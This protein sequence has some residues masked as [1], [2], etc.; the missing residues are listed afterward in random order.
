MSAPLLCLLLL[1]STFIPSS[2]AI[3]RAA[4]QNAPSL[5]NTVDEPDAQRLPLTRLQCG[6]RFVKN[7][8][9][10]V[11]IVQQQE[12][13]PNPTLLLLDLTQKQQQ[14]RG[15]QKQSTP[16]TNVADAAPDRLECGCHTVKVTIRAKVPKSAD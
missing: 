8:I 10:A 15:L 16:P 13:L 12:A 7:R 4:F 1:I 6:C 5:K 2:T 3:F 9:Q 11:P 14:L